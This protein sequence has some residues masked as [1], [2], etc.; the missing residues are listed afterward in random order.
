MTVDMDHAKDVV[1]VYFYGSYMNRAVLGEAGLTPRSWE[2]ATL[3]GFD[4]HIRPRANLVRAPGV[5]VWGI[6]AGASHEELDRLYA[7][8]REVL[9][10][11]YL[12]Q[13]VLVELAGGG[14]RPALC[15]VCPHMRERP[16]ADDYI[17][18]IL[19]PAR[20]HGFPASYLERIERFRR[21]GDLS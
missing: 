14:F 6:L 3:A 2:V 18:R 7:H 19:A 20:D 9:G 8:A 11:V 12:P 21:R 15:Y 13:A 16:A 1:A 4:I 5:A 17:D 10:E